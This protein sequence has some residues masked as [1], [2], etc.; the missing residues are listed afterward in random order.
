MY[1]VGRDAAEGVFVA[2]HLTQACEVQQRTLSMAGG[3]ISKVVVPTEEVLDRQ[4]AD[5]MAS[6]DY[7]AL[8][9]STIN[10]HGCVPM[11]R[12]AWLL[13]EMHIGCDA[14]S[15]ASD[16]FFC[17]T[18]VQLVLGLHN[19]RLVASTAVCWFVLGVQ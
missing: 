11:C 13:T 2:T 7:G 16:F 17:A 10:M 3:D 14:A 12:C 15:G 8:H 19:L 5:M 9:L 18:L 1:A 4:Y 6:T